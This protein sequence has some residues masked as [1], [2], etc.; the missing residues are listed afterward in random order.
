MWLITM[1]LL[2]S[3]A[4]IFVE[5]LFCFFFLHFLIHEIAE[6]ATDYR[7]CLLNTIIRIVILFDDKNQRYAFIF[8]ELQSPSEFKK[9]K[10]VNKMNKYT[11]FKISIKFSFTSLYGLILIKYQI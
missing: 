5:S 7:L 6:L 1:I 2:L 4:C 3:F 11:S 8:L 10:E 9:I